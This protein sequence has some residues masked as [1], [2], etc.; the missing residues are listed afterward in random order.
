M[1]GAY[2]LAAVVIVAILAVGGYMA[3]RPAPSEPVG[4]T[5]V[6]VTDADCLFNGGTHICN[7]TIALRKATTTPCAI[8]SPN[9]T[10]T[11]VRF[12]TRIDIASSS[13]TIWDIARSTTAFA[14]TTA[15]GTAYNI[16]AAAS[17][18]IDAST[19]PTTTQTNIFA[20]NTWV[21]LGARGGNSTGDNTTPLGF[22][23]TG[24]CTAQFVY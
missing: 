19:T 1:K 12:T 24:T 4:A 23:P 6:Q 20:P 16:V 22:V 5:S 14:T 8:K 9:A 10:S 2:I 18:F 17:G 7:Q 15:I 11:L 21:V 3:L 13:A